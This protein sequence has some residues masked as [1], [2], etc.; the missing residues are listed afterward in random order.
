M[1]RGPTSDP[2]KRL[3]E[4]ML[5]GAV[6]LDAATATIVL[7][8]KAAAR[9][10]G[11]A[12]PRDMV[13]VSPLDYVPEEDREQVVQMMAES[14]ERDRGSPSEIRIMTKDKRMLWVS[15]SV[16]IIEH[17]GKK[18]TLTTVRDIT[19]EKAKDAALREAERRYEHLFDGMLDGAVVLDISTFQIAL[20]NKAAADMFGF[21]S[22]LEI[23]GENPLSYI[24][25]DDRDEVARQIALN[26]QG[27]GPNPAE[28]R[29][30]TRDKRTD[31]YA[32]HIEGHNRRQGQRRSAQGSRGKQ[33]PVDRRRG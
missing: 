15:A 11:F 29:V 19:S 12:S 26:L 13:G 3:F 28:V 14:F 20:A 7:A 2:Y 1:D 6:V 23:V 30:I 25:E 18:A 17:E 4:T 9:I 16:T 24:P 10:F 27:E 5:D 8:N 31:G 32:D 33:T 22:P 21:S